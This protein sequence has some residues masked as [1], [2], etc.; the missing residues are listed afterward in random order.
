VTLGTL[1]AIHPHGQPRWTLGI[2][3][4]MKRTSADRA[5]IG[6]SIVADTIAAVG[7]NEQRKRM[8]D[9]NSIDGEGTT[10]NR[11]RFG[12][13]QLSRRARDGEPMVQSLVVPAVEYQGAKRYQLATGK[14]EY[15]IRFGRLIEQQPDWVWTA[16]EPLDASTR[17]PAAPVA[18]GPPT[19]M[20]PTTTGTLGPPR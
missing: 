2:I 18:P 3:R 1:V 8:A 13:L 11:R 4:R 20:G 9:D 5:E 14:A 15:R 17:A 7:L 19:G 16:I 12:G 6:L 10:I